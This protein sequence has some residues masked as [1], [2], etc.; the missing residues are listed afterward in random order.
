[1]KASR[2]FAALFASTVA[3]I[4]ANAAHAVSVVVNGNTYE[5]STFTGSYEANASKFTTTQMA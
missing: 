3:I 4:S 1:M 5:V 2:T